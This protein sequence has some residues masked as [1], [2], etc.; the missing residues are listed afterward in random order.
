MADRAEAA[1]ADWLPGTAPGVITG[2][3]FSSPAWP[4]GEPLAAAPSTAA[5]RIRATVQHLMDMDFQFGGGYVRRM[6]LFFFQSEV[7]P[8]LRQRYPEMIHAAR[9]EGLRTSGAIR[10]ARREAFRGPDGE[11]TR[12]PGPTEVFGYRP[13]KPELYFSWRGP[14]PN[15]SSPAFWHSR[16]RPVAAAG[17]VPTAVPAIASS[18]GPNAITPATVTAPVH[19]SRSR[20]RTG[21]ATTT[22]KAAPITRYSTAFDV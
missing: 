15:Q 5:G 3:L 8:L 1:Q 7:V 20:R 12:P 16:P 14:S 10:G 6:L 9:G 2:Y 18:R 4:Q 19:V 11:G 13:D 21:R 17:Q 22:S